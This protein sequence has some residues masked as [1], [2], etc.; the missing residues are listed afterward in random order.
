MRIFWMLILSLEDC[1]CLQW[2]DLLNVLHLAEYQKVQQVL[3]HQ[4]FLLVLKIFLV[5]QWSELYKTFNYLW[6]FIVRL[7]V[8]KYKGLYRHMSYLFVTYLIEKNTL[9]SLKP[10]RDSTKTICQVFEHNTS[11]YVS[12]KLDF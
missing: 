1:Y 6:H 3:I 7:F 11:P 5:L 9:Q 12:L 2:S 4:R 10:T 8:I